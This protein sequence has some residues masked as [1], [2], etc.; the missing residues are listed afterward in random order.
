MADQK[1]IRINRRDFLKLAGLSLSAA[2]V[3]TLLQ[4]CG[5]PASTAAPAATTAPEAT[6]AVPAGQTLK[7][8]WWG[9]QE[10]PGL[11]KWMN[12][13]IARFK[14]KTGHS[15]E[16]TLQDT[17]VVISEFQ[18]ASAAKNAPDLQFL[19][20]GIYH[21][22]SVWL[23]YLDPLDSLIPMDEIQA[24]NPTRLSYFEGK[25]YRMGWYSAGP[26]WLYNKEIFEKAG[27]GEEPPKTWDELM[28]FCDKIKTAGFIPISAGLKDGPW[29]EWFMGHGLG[30][31][32]DSPADAINL[33]IGSLDWREPRYYEHWSRVEELWKAGFFNDDMN[34]I[35]LY[36]GIDLFGAGKAGMTAIVTPLAASQAKM[37]GGSEKVGG[38]VFPVFGK[39]K[40][41]GKPIAD[42][43]GFGISSQSKNKEIAAEFIRFMHEPERV[44]AL[45]EASNVL[46]MDASFDPSKITDPLL[47]QIWKGWVGNPDAV[48]YISNL[49]PV[50]FWTDAMFVNSQKII[51]GEWTGEQA[52][53]NAYEVTQK[54]VEQNPDLVEK[55][56]QWAKDL[57]A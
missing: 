9:E 50:L 46:P 32:L 22:E 49:M 1:T 24:T 12:E 34:S 21:M 20:N 10:A 14:E 44:E 57:G 15:I 52:G 19:W 3:S 2:G 30:Q 11:E 55:Y 16:P 54:W 33:F 17:T 29:G 25:P 35:D 56:S 43:Q 18:T 7:M 4:S 13:T 6:K 47:N 26:M 42:C 5:A 8:W 39:G 40:M 48:P 38:M 27:L 37:L 28:D 23:G 36:P 45:W 53:Q 41:A 51:A 31:N